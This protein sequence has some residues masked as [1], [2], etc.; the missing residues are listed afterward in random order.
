VS[1]FAQHIDPSLTHFEVAHLQARR[2]DTRRGCIGPS[3]LK[4]SV[5]AV[6][7]LTPPAKDVPGFQP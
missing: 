4:L 1:D 6:R 3:G 5:F 7:W 2:A